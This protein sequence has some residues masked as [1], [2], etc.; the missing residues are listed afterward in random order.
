MTENPVKKAGF[1][2]KL[3]WLG[4]MGG[5]VAG[6]VLGPYVS[7]LLVQTNP[8]FFGPDNQNIIDK[9]QANFDRLDETLA[10]LD[11]LQ[12]GGGAG[13]ELVARLTT[14]MN[15]Q[16]TLSEQKNELFKTTDTAK[17]DL[18][19]E[20]LEKHGASGAV[21]FWVRP[22]ESIVLRERD[23]VFTVLKGLSVNTAQVNLS[24]KQSRMGIGDSLE[25]EISTGACKL[26]YRQDNR[27][28]DGLFGFDL[29]CD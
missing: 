13:G 3:K 28:T 18:K 15:E 16:R 6:L 7:Q 19:E 4:T 12:Q 29:I 2:S 9:Q 1:M 21:D 27:K 5:F 17:Q 14:L 20:L 22:G 8:G 11:K 23:Q 26:F 24:G 10:E 25:F